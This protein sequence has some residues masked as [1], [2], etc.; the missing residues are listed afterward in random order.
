[1]HTYALAISTF[2][3]RLS[4]STVISLLNSFAWKYNLYLFYNIY[5][6]LKE[7]AKLE[8]KCVYVKK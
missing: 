3:L 2:R 7:M 6:W 8:Y 5:T 4:V 1:M